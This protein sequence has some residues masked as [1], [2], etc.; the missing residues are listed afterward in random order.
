MP[1]RFGYTAILFCLIFCK[2]GHRQA[3]LKI[4]EA[5]KAGILYAVS[6]GAKSTLS[7]VYVVLGLRC[8][9]DGS[10]VNMNPIPVTLYICK[11]HVD[12]I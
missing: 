2:N 10:N 11:R 6:N 12:I 4:H 9:V 3:S 5:H 8:L 7:W 1:R